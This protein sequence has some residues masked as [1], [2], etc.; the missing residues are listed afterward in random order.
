MADEAQTSRFA[1]DRTTW[2]AA[3]FFASVI[4]AHA[5]GV[6]GVVTYPLVI[7]GGI[8]CVCFGLRRNQPHV[9]WPWWAFVASG[10]IWA[11]AGVARESTGATG[12]QRFGLLDERIS[13]LEAVAAGDRAA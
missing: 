11:I 3:G 4:A 6:L 7:A 13:A 1:S 2:I 8:V 5:L 9:R 10:L 12:D